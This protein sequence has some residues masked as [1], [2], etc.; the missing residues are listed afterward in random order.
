MYTRKNEL[1]ITEYGAPQKYYSTE[2]VPFRLG[3]SSVRTGMD[4]HGLVSQAQ[5]MDMAS[6]GNQEN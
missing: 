3:F 2:N 1:L 4:A 6:S 5:T